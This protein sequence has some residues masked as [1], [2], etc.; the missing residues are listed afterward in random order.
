MKYFKNPFNTQVRKLKNLN[1]SQKIHI[2]RITSHT[3]MMISDDNND[4]AFHPT[5]CRE[6]K[7]LSSVHLM[8]RLT[9]I[10][11]GSF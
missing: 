4:G 6:L 9:V 3:S 7:L 5:E 2:F 11:K 10:L 8:A 1:H